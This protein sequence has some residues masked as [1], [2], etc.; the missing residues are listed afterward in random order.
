[1]FG[2]FSLYGFSH[3]LI[4]Q[5]LHASSYFSKE[6]WDMESTNIS[7]NYYDVFEEFGL[8]SID[9]SKVQIT[10]ALKKM[11]DDN[12]LRESKEEMFVFL[13]RYVKGQIY[14][15]IYGLGYKSVVDVDTSSLGMKDGHEYAILDLSLVKSGSSN[16]VS[17][18]DAKDFVKNLK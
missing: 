4:G 2:T 1:M 3:D 14:S 16:S 7:R 17:L 15:A 18:D 9:G 13:R 12:E 11:I 8:V 5:F 10:D 6:S